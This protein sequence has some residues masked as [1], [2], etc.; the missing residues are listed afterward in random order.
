MSLKSRLVLDGV[1]LA[2]HLAITWCVGGLWT[3]MWPGPDEPIVFT[4]AGVSLAIL[5]V[6]RA[7]VRRR[8]GL[9]EP[10]S[11]ARL[12]D[13]EQRLA[14][15]DAVQLRVLE[16]EER[17]DFAERLLADERSRRPELTQGHAG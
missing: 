12:E 4:V 17:L 13:V 1:G 6:N 10:A 15:L 7:L 2:I 14:E 8:G 11:F 16:L 9:D 3:T 5:A